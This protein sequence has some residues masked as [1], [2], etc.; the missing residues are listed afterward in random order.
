M[1]TTGLII[2]GFI[3]CFLV[4]VHFG[5]KI[6]LMRIHNFEVTFNETN[7]S[8]QIILKDDKFDPEIKA[9]KIQNQMGFLHGHLLSLKKG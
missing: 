9:K 8:L 6:Q 1:G 3:V 2:I 4:G 7:E 5:E